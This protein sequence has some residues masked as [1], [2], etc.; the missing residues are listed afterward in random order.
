M[1][2]IDYTKKPVR[3]GI[4]RGRRW[5]RGGEFWGV[6][7]SRGELWDGGGELLERGWEFWE[8][9]LL[10]GGGGGLW[11]RRGGLWGGGEL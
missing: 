1:E 7:W 5:G 10:G 11:R 6:L 9:G 3:R 2:V 8:E 4:E